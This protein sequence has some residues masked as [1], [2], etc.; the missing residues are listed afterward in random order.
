MITQ[1]DNP[2]NFLIQTPWH[3]N[4]LSWMPYE[5]A[6]LIAKTGFDTYH[7]FSIKKIV[8]SMLHFRKLT[9]DGRHTTTC[10]VHVS[11]PERGHVLG[12]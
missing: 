8:A 9:S 12:Q 5:V 10:F 1:R 11:T 4:F 6:F 7:F 2:L 3:P